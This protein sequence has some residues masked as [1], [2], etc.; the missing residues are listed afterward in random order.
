[1]A[2]TESEQ[3]AMKILARTEIQTERQSWGCAKVLVKLEMGMD[4]PEDVE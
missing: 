1:M 2:A 3:K 4:F